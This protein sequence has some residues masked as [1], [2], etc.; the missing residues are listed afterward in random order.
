[1]TVRREFWSRDKQRDKTPVLQSC[2][3]LSGDKVP[4]SVPCIDRRY[5]P[6]RGRGLV[7]LGMTGSVCPVSGAQEDDG[8]LLLGG[9]FDSCLPSVPG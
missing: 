9:R 5:R 2:Q 1:M 6:G 7:H 4:G 8:T 3:S